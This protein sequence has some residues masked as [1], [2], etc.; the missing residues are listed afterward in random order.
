MTRNVPRR[1][2]K[3]RSNTR[4]FKFVDDENN[5]ATDRALCVLRRPVRAKATKPTKTTKTVKTYGEERPGTRY[6]ASARLA[7]K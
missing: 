3:R 7:R 4:R 5:L 1:E 2:S 6:S